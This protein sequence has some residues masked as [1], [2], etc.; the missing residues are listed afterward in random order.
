MAA[1]RAS[2]ILLVHRTR[3]SQG[4]ELAP[5]ALVRAAQLGGVT[6]ELV[7][8]G[9]RPR[10]QREHRLAL[11]AAG[12]P[13]IAAALAP[14]AARRAGLEAAREA[15]HAGRSGPRIREVAGVVSGAALAT[16]RA[17]TGGSRPMSVTMLERFAR[18]PFQGYAATLAASGDELARETPDAREEGNL[19][20]EALRIA[21]EAIDLAKRP[22]DADALV[23]T[24]LAAIDARLHAAHAAT[25]RNIAL[26]RAKAEVE[27]VVRA[28]AD[29]EAWDFLVAE[30]SFGRQAP[31]WPELVIGKGEGAVTLRGAMDRVDRAHGDPTRIRVIDYKR[32]Q[33]HV[34]ASELG[35]KR[36]QLLV[37]GV[38]A[39]RELHAAHFDGLYL[40]TRAA[41]EPPPPS[42]REAW[43]E[44]ASEQAVTAR[45]L[46]IMAPVRDGEVLPA[47][48]PV[49][50]T[51]PFDGACRKPRFALPEEGEAS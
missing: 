4:E 10:T 30:Q 42:F 47:P 46:E 1:E 44:L 20:H 39:A 23:A 21:F 48:G 16:L 7:R 15:W 28:A 25:L 27:Q 40:P 22:R 17:E 14:S 35:K 32:R 31:S 9:D 41:T 8:A 12:S 24:A 49:C 50:S 34:A 26:V 11:L 51:C 3:G 6:R 19:V 33:D 5:A 29:D 45:V 36:L 18:C 43:M 38:A 37:Y 13:E 2:K